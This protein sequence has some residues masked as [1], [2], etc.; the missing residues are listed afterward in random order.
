MKTCDQIVNDLLN[1]G[2]AN[3]DQAQ[4]DPGMVAY[5]NEDRPA[6]L[7]AVEAR[8]RVIADGRCPVCLKRTIRVPNNAPNYCPG[9][10][11]E[12]EADVA[13]LADEALGD[14]RHARR[15]REAARLEPPEEEA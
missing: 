13:A 15:E 4:G 8:L 9:C 7:D 12:P 3:A 10:G 6:L 14:L 5:W 2:D 1:L 11:Y